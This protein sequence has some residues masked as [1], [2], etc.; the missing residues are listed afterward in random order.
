MAEVQSRALALPEHKV[1][2]L[3]FDAIKCPGSYIYTLYILVV[4]IILFPFL[5][6]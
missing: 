4:Y 1:L 5:C 6:L 2:E 3:L